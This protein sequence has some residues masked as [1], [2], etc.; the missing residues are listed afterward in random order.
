M[1]NR[2]DFE[3]VGQCPPPPLFLF[4]FLLLFFS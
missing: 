2:A 4:L 3:Y 1:D